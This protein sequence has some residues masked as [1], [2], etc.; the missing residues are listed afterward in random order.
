MVR[1]MR[2]SGHSTRR[3]LRRGRGLERRDCYFQ[4]TPPPVGAGEQSIERQIWRPALEKGARKGR[5][6]ALT[7]NGE[8]IFRERKMSS[9]AAPKPKLTGEETV[10]EQNTRGVK[11]ASR[12]AS[13][14]RKRTSPRIEMELRSEKEKKSSTSNKRA[15]WKRRKTR[16]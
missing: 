11:D 15:C 14:W 3:E 1:E 5:E 7:N 12:S 10:S 4:R 6:G 2:R 8:K 13:R 9:R 16:N